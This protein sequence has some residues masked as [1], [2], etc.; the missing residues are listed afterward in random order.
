M[1][2]MQ[3]ML[4]V[5]NQILVLKSNGQMELTRV[6]GAARTHFK[7]LVGLPKNATHLQVLFALG[8]AYKDNKLE[9]EFFDLVK[10]LKGD[11]FITPEALTEAYKGL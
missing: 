5:S 1:N 6:A 2:K 9:T 4:L 7:K 10:R 11:E 8:Q 3:L